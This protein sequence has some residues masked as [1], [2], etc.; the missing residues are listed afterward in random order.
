MNICNLS[1][2]ISIFNQIEMQAKLITFFLLLFLSNNVFGQYNSSELII[3]RKKMDSLKILVNSN[4]ADSLKVMHLLAFVDLYSKAFLPELSSVARTKGLESNYRY[5]SQALQLAKKIKYTEGILYSMEMVGATQMALLNYDDALLCYQ[6]GIEIAESKKL[7]KHCH[8][9]YRTLMN[10]YFYK[11]DFSNAMQVATKGLSLSEKN[12]EDTLSAGYLNVIGFIHLRQNNIIESQKYYTQYLVT[13]RKLNDSI[14]IADADNSLADALL[15]QNKYTIALDYNNQALKIYNSLK[16][17]KGFPR[18][19]KIPYTLFKIGYLYGQKGDFE[20]ALDYLYECI[21]ITK[22]H[23]GDL[24]DDAKYYIYTGHIYNRLHKYNSAANVLHTGLVLSI[25]IKH[26]ENIRDAYQ[27]LSE[28]FAGTKMFDSAYH[29]TV[30]FNNLKDS[31]SNEKTR[32]DIANINDVY[33]LDKKN[34]QIELLNQQKKLQDAEIRGNIMQRNIIIGLAVLLSIVGFLLYKRYKLLNKAQKQEEINRRQNELFNISTTIQDQERKRIAQDLHDGLGSLLSAAKLKLSAL[35]TGDEHPRQMKDILHLLDDAATELRNISQN[36]MPAALSKLGL[37]ASLQSIFDSIS[38][39]SDL[40][41]HFTMHGFDK[42]LESET[43]I[44]I[45]RIVLELVNNVVKHASA[46]NVTVQLIRYPDQVNLTVEDDGQ[47]FDQETVLNGT[48]LNNIRSR[49]VYLKGTID[50]DT[51]E[52]NGTTTIIN[53][54]Y[55][56]E[57]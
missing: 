17:L 23:H 49:I 34:Q 12:N 29:Y 41:I 42:R 39:G 10:L 37:E 16:R 24:Y 46:N 44:S 50:M 30:L 45:Y 6:Q 26:N 36:I 22:I 51:S 33:Q 4:E 32:S 1:A 14:M 28:M 5:A 27:Y 56:N 31:I 57:K 48:G 7:Y 52:Q 2:T 40:A 53:I 9:L 13:A 38:G 8:S 43:E 3:A 11:G 20:N 15:A 25:Q 54:P 21:K 47:G 35:Q 18:K 55:T 19:S